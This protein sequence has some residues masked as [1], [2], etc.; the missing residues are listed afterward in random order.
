MV[1][2]LK[3][4]QRELSA[5]GHEVHFATPE[6]HTTLPLPTYPEIRLALYPR[7]RLLRAFETF[8][9]DAIHIATEGTMG[10][11]A[12]Q[13]CLER[14]LPFTTAFHTRFPEY[15]HARLPFVPESAVFA[16]LKTFHAPAAATMVS[17]P[18]LMDELKSD[19]FQNLRL[20]TRGVDV[21]HFAPGPSDAFERLGRMPARPIFLYVGRLAVE[22]NV[23]A[24]L[25]LDL[26]GSKV[27]I[28]DGPQ[29]SDLQARYPAVHFLGH[30]T[31]EELA[32]LYAAGDVFVFPS[33]TDTFGLVI[34]EA[35][36]SGLPVAAYPVTGPL[37]VLGGTAA[38]ALD[39]DLRTACLKALT[40][41]WHAPRALALNY[42]W[43]ASAEQFLANLAVCA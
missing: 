8:R 22:K 37:D 27:V 16:A 36:A 35:L 7:G 39:E 40:V 18:T 41:P 13:I 33:L 17:T 10:L 1:R 4:L 12:R 25:A 24:F 11:F 42:S 5:L 43:R 32:R 2:T 30:R 9:P 38:G 23:D 3:V 20:W 6:H 21:E 15:V 26:P 28:G 19:G 31:S 34:L 14:R 29:R